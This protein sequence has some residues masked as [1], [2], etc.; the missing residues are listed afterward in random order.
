[1][2]EGKWYCKSC[3]YIGSRCEYG[4]IQYALIWFS[5]LF[6]ASLSSVQKEAYSKRIESWARRCPECRKKLLIPA[7][8]P[9]ARRLIKSA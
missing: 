7:D 6:T 3:E 8:S 4:A 1:M 9:E 2:I 5:L